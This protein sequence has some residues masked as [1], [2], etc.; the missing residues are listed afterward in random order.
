MKGK[1]GGQWNKI[2]MEILQ[3]NL[4]WF[5][6]FLS[7]VLDWIVLILVWFERS[8][9]SAQVSV[10]SWPWP[11]KLM[12]SRGVER[13]WIHTGGYGRFRGEWVKDCPHWW[14]SHR[15]C[16]V[17]RPPCWL[18]WL[19]CLT[20]RVYLGK[21]PFRPHSNQCKLLLLRALTV[22]TRYKT[23]FWGKQPPTEV[24]LLSLNSIV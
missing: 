13:T 2:F 12:T 1:V 5:F 24:K 19:V 11:L 8:L 10:Q 3:V 22:K 16:R 9:H 17:R 6:A 23:N 18:V 20:I 14:Q 4:A 7:G 15:K 21:G